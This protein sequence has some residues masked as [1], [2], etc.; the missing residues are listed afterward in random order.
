MNID[1]IRLAGNLAHSA[2]CDELLVC[3][4]S[5]YEDEADLFEE[6]GNGLEYKEDVSLVY[7]RWYNYFTA[8]IDVC[9]TK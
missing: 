9:E 2:T 6:T 7:E 3:D 5:D 1:K 4:H 8:A